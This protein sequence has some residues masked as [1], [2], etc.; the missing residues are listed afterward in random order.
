MSTLNDAI[1]DSFSTQKRRTYLAGARPLSSAE[2]GRL[3][4]VAGSQQQLRTGSLPG[5][6][7]SV[8]VLCGALWVRP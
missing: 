2:L 5:P 6:L 7:K 3:L 1:A 4:L 8:A